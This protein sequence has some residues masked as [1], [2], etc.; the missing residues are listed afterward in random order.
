MGFLNIG[1]DGENF[2]K[3]SLDDL[4]DD[5]DIYSDEPKTNRDCIAKLWEDL[6]FLNNK[7][8]LEDWIDNVSEGYAPETTFFSHEYQFIDTCCM[9]HNI[10]NTYAELYGQEKADRI[11]KRL[12][13]IGDEWNSI[14][15]EALV[16]EMFGAHDDNVYEISY[17]DNNSQALMEHGSFWKY[18]R[19]VK[20]SHH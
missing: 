12:E 18:I 5:C 6:L 7:A 9:P 2:S 20:I 17:S 4:V 10:S 15:G 11:A 14:V 13:K 3:L 1:W 16:R 19:H 8:T